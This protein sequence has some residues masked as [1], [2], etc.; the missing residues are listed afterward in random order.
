MKYAGRVIL[1]STS[2]EFEIDGDRAKEI[3][4]EC[5]KS[6]FA[7]S[8]QEGVLT[9]VANDGSKE[10]LIRHSAIQALIIEKQA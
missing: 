2:L 6:M 4:N 5:K 10:T 1:A 7:P 8:C 9:I 3:L